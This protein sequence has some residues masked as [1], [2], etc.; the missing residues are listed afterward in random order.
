MSTDESKPEHKPHSADYFGE[1]R[2]FWWNLDFLQLMAKRI[3][4]TNVNK[5]L[6]VGCGIG[7]WSRV[8][9]SILPKDAQLIGIDLEDAWVKEATKLAVEYGLNDRFYYQLGNALNIDFPDNSFDMVTCQT[10]LIHLQNP[11]DALKEF[12]RVLKPN[13]ILLIAEPSSVP[14]NLWAN[15]FN[16]PLNIDTYTQRIRFQHICETGKAILGEGWISAGELIPAHLSKL[17]VNDIQV[18]LSDKCNPLFPPYNQSEEQEVIIKSVLENDDKNEETWIWDLKTTKKYFTAAMQ[19]EYPNMKAADI[20]NEFTKNWEL[21]QQLS[22]ALRIS[23]RNGNFS[24]GGGAVM[25]LIT[26]RKG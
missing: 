24:T 13:G 9:A 14:L 16:P 3:N 21:E 18:Y 7:H 5:V 19:K 11:A 8:L 26:A 22:K 15:N 4:L 6:D 23:I 1:S 17:N 2:N 12:I 10:L 20:E 25:Y